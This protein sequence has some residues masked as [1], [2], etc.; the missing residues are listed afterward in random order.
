[1]TPAAAPLP[2]QVFLSYSHNDR[3]AALALRAALEAAGLSVFRDDESIRSG[4]RWLERLQAAVHGCSAFVVLAGR[5]GVRRWVGA[6]VQV[7]LIRHLSP[8]ADEQR[9]PLFPVLL[10]D[11]TPESLPPFLA[12]F[13]ACCWAPPEAV[14]AA[15]IDAINQA[16]SNVVANAIQASRP[17]QSQ[18]D[19]EDHVHSPDGN[20]RGEDTYIPKNCQPARLFVAPAQSHGGP[21]TDGRSDVELAAD[22]FHSRLH[23]LQACPL[24]WCLGF[25][26]APSVAD[27]QQGRCLPDYGPDRHP[28]RSRVPC[29][30]G[31]CF[32][33][34]CLQH[35]QHLA[36]DLVLLDVCLLYTSPSPRDRT[37]SRMPSSA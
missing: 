30:V 10:P 6:E 23:R 27:D 4:D 28:G 3:P 15:L 7:A 20:H 13:Q 8:A 2:E 37:R 36:G 32:H 22:G 26:S 34:C 31:Q 17:G 33:G 21:G 24:A 12:L 29:H 5:D 9:L 11:V 35:V 14:P 1:M 25:E 18:P 19:V 16:V